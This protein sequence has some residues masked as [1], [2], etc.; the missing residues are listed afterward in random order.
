MTFLWA[1]SKLIQKLNR[2]LEV[3]LDKLI[4]TRSSVAICQDLYIRIFLLL[5]FAFVERIYFLLHGIS[6][7]EYVG[8]NF[9]LYKK[10]ATKKKR[11]RNNDWEPWNIWAILNIHPVLQNNYIL[12]RT[13]YKKWFIL[14]VIKH[15]ES[16]ITI[17][18]NDNQM[19]VPIL[20][21][22]PDLVL[23]NKIWFGLVWF[24]GTSTIV[25]Y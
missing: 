14:E 13:K 22:K 16:G 21:R 7:C 6:I 18:N 4:D 15:L 1:N 20:A 9:F 25:G 23:I 3:Q 5:H 12:K 8:L 11:L 10:W 17:N 19:D 24:Y 2:G